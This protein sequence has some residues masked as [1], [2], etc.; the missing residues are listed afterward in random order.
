MGKL[1]ISKF[2][3]KA[4]TMSKTSWTTDFKI[5]WAWL[6]LVDLQIGFQLRKGQDYFAIY[7]MAELGDVKWAHVITHGWISCVFGNQCLWLNLISFTNHQ[8]LVIIRAVTS[9]K[10]SRSDYLCEWSAYACLSSL[11]SKKRQIKFKIRWTLISVLVTST[12]G[13]GHSVDH[14]I[15]HQPKHVIHSN[16]IC[17]IH[18]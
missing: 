16:M 17:P 7:M 13:W 11:E 15:S 14:W 2:R 1:Y 9:K 4:L 10:P 5:K 18:A 8:N 12:H 6:V 3:W